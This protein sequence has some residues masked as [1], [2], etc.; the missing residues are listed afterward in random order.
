MRPQRIAASF[1][2]IFV[3]RNQAIPSLD[4]KAAYCGRNFA[5]LKSP[6]F[7]LLLAAMHIDLSRGEFEL[8]V[9]GIARIHEPMALTA[10]SKRAYTDRI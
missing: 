6:I 7:K 1:G 10:I 5:C 2:Q 9:Y 4:Q 8:M 3:S